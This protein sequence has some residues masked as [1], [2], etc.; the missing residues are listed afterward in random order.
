MFSEAMARDSVLTVTVLNGSLVSFASGGFASGGGSKA[1]LSLTESAVELFTM[2]GLELSLTLEARG[3]EGQSAMVTVRFVSSARPFGASE[4]SV[5]A[6]GLSEATMGAEI[7]ASGSSGLSIWHND[8]GEESYELE[9]AADLFGLNEEGRVTAAGDLSAGV[10]HLTLRLTGGGATAE[11]SLRVEVSAPS[12]AIV[13]PSLSIASLSELSLEPVTVLWNAEEGARALTVTLRGGTKARFASSS[14]GG[15]TATGGGTEAT[16]SLTADAIAVFVT[17]GLELE[18]ALTATDAAGESATVT[19]R[20]VSSSRPFGADEL[21]VAALELSEATM[22]AE[23]VASGGSG[24]SIWHND[25]GEESYELEQAA[26]VFG[27]DAAGRVTVASAAGLSAGVYQLTLRLTDGEAT[28]GLT[29]RLEVTAAVLEIASLSELSL[30]PVPVLWNAEEGAR[31]LTVTLRGGT[32]ARFASSSVGGLTATGG[33][34]EATVSLTADAI[35]V[36]ATDGLELELALTATDAAGESAT[37]TTRFVS[38]SR[39]FGADELS[40]AALELSAATLGAEIVASGGS[41]LSIW[42]NDDGEES[43]EL[44]QAADVFG[45]DAAGRVT[46]ASAA[47]LSAGVYQLTLR[48]TDGEATAGLTMRLEVTAAVLEIASLSELSSGPVPVLWDAEEGARALTV[49]LRGGTKARFASSSVG[50]LT[51][52]GGGTEATVSLTADAIAVFATDGLELELAL[53]ASDA[54]GESATVTTRFVS[55]SRPFG[56]DE[57]SLAALELSEATMGAEIVASGGSGLSIWHNDDGEESY[58]LEQAADLFGVDAAGRVTVASAA[59]LSAGV[60]QLTL[61]LTDGEATA[62]LTM[63]LEVTAAVLEIASLSE[64]SSGPV[65]VLWDA[66]E[67][68]R[69]LT[70]TLRGGTKARFASSSVGG[71]TATGGGTEATVSLTADAIAVFVT[72]GL[73]LE[74]ALTATDA[75]GESATVTTRFVSSSRP[76]GADELSVAALELSAA[77][78]GAEIVASGGSGLSIWHNDDGEE[79]YELEQAADLFGVDAAGRVT[80]SSAAGL[81]AG[82]YQL[83]L[84]LT[85]GE[86]TAGLTM[87]L[88]VTAA[89]L[90]IA[91]LSELSSGPVPVLW[92]AEEGARALTVTLRGGTKARFASSSVGGLTA[93]GGGTE[94]TV[95]LTADAIAVFVTDGLELELALTA[96]D[97]AGESA[98]VTTRFVSSS[99]PFGADEL[100][101]AALELSAATLGAEIVAS[102]GSGLSI[103]HNDDGEE[104]YE[105]EQAADVFGVDAAGRV[106]VASAAG[107]SAGVYQLTLRLTDGEATAGLTMR[108]E[109]TAA[110][111]EIA[112]LSELSSVPVPVLWDAEEGAR[113]LTVTLRGGTKA[114]FASSSVGGLT[115]TGGGTEATVSLTADAIAVFATDGLELEL[116][117]TASDAAGESA[118]VTTRFVSSSRPFGA[119]ELS[120]AALELSEATM[121]AE[122]VASGGS[123][124]SIW[125]NDDGE[126]SYE[127]EQ[128][129]DLFGVDAAGRVTVSSAAGLSAGVYQL[130]LRLTDGEATA[131]LTMRLEVTAAVLEI[132]SLSELSLEP[133]PVLWNAEEGARALTVT[134]RGGTK[135]RFASSSVGG[136]TAT[137]GGTEATVSLT[138]DAIAVFATDGLELELALTASDAT[139]QSATVTTRFV[140]SAR[141]FGASELSVAA[142]ELSAATLGAEIVASGS[143]GLSIWHNDDG[144]ESY[145]LEQ[146]AGLFGV[147]RETGRVTVASAAGLSAG[148]YQLTLRLTD[149]EA[150]AGLTMRLEVTAAVLE[151][152]SLSELSLEPV[153]VLWNAE[154]GARALTVTLRGERR[155]GLRRRRLAA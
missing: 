78:L 91:S 62:G 97:A 37:V 46:V 6:L 7:V 75:A 153:P 13:S 86:A 18:L 43:Y 81:S 44:E 118:T 142:L 29:M 82:V 40:V 134:L 111:L 124:L 120:L 19:T 35:A 138:A 58:E 85:D 73:E 74:L 53:T 113:A 22:G 128:A 140:S 84:R 94:A 48:L 63:R 47:G 49:T 95:S 143:S 70:V 149:G 17:D 104:S 105:L 72:D 66:E 96:T 125:H 135:A 42:H 87:R 141:G 59:G 114:R 103:W 154:E 16:V 32:K 28:A 36:F 2:D 57:L 101:V 20:F 61:R 115:A 145:E 34:T 137:G 155:R 64:L 55:S 127:L 67:G 8:D 23:I 148:V 71:L 133:V 132:A 89:V 92:D 88:E 116:A 119:D 45:V 146:A 30:E 68:A 136:L 107:L 150:T 60:Y 126:E 102:G 152:A 12:L 77:T 117:L 21:S 24:L 98:T 52:T 151:I 110:V 15:L 100:S 4:L 11:L 147:N 122:I 144:E 54:A 65:P 25:D 129:A 93:T 130:T 9:Q 3:G 31:A 83:T 90:E 139:G 109:V 1:A 26:D 5:V 112:S 106:T 123:G 121:G 108:L 51:A 27:V 99:R 41:G 131:G 80:V 50:G 76:F 69:A 14:V 56:A 10:Y 38:S 33:G 79:S 39:P